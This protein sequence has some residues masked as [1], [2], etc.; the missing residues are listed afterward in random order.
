MIKRIMICTD[1][2]Q[3]G[4]AALE[5]GVYLAGALNASLIALHVID[6]RLLEGPLM[7]DISGWVGATPYSAQLRQFREFFQ[8]KGEA[9]LAA[10]T[11]RFQAAGLT[12]VETRLKM[13]HPARV[14]L[15]EE[16][17]A[18]M[19]IMGRRGEHE[20]WMG[21]LLGSNAERVSRQSVKPCLLTPGHFAPF[22]R[23]MAAYDGSAHASQAVTEAAELAQALKCP[24]VVVT[25]DNGDAQAAEGILADGLQ[26]AQSHADDVRGE[27][28]PGAAVEV[29][30]D[31]VSRLECDLVVAG[32]Y[33][34]S[35]I[36]EM[37][38]GSA[39]TR[40]LAATEAPVMLVR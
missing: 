11:E 26:L 35:R 20:P 7:A 3:Y 15:E 14:I 19:V 8:Q 37:I 4:E 40:L 39:T 17:R 5:Y 21:D 32:A 29:L 33:G 34:H 2:S 18:E 31:A 24:L 38:I 16:A 12:R 30:P 1:G 10:C 25:A 9:V 23:I 27:R 28:L 13:G 6:S 36:R 22:T